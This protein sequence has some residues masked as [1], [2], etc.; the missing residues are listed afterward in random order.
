MLG[1]ARGF[2][3][4]HLIGTVS[5]P[6]PQPPSPQ[7]SMSRVS[8]QALR[9]RGRV[10]SIL[11]SQL[12]L[13]ER[14]LLSSQGVWNTLL[15]LWSW[16]GSSLNSR[17]LR[18]VGFGPP[19]RI[20]SKLRFRPVLGVQWCLLAQESRQAENLQHLSVICSRLC[21]RKQETLFPGVAPWLHFTNKV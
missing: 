6:P 5:S 12:S 18:H 17:D 1:T 14:L 13:T 19:C 20:L 2:R 9:S 15:G 4:M 16:L 10:K 11:F 21:K 8:Q 3:L 7:H